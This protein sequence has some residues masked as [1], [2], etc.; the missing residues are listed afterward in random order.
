LAAGRSAGAPA[1]SDPTHAPIL[2]GTRQVFEVG[3]VEGQAAAERAA[4]INRRIESFVRQPAQIRPVEVQVRGSE[5][6]LVIGGRQILTVTDQ[7]AAD[8]LTT[9]PAL[10]ILWQGDL[11]N[12]LADVRAQHESF[13]TQISGAILQ[14]AEN[15]L[16][17]VA[18]LIPRLVSAL[19][20][21]FLTIFAARGS[22]SAPLR[23]L[24]GAVADANTRQIVQ[25]LTYYTVWLLGW[26]VAFGTLGIDPATLVAGLGITTIAL[27]FALKDLLSNFVSGFLILTTRPFR[28]GDEIAV[29]EFEGTVDRIDLRATHLRTYYNRLVL[30][31]NADLYTATIVNNTA[32]PHRR[33]EFVVGVAYDTDLAEARETAL[34]V[35]AETPGVLA[36]PPPDV[37]VDDL[38][39]DAIRLK[40]RFHSDPRRLQGVVVSSEVKRRL[41]QAFEAAGITI[42][43]ATPVVQIQY[44]PPPVTENGETRPGGGGKEEAVAPSRAA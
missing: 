11:E 35:A 2:V 19:L 1:R 44:P 41:L 40:L 26:V 7:D 32:T 36:Q 4:A 25:T 24:R 38:T 29:K 20:V 37:L 42:P 31:P 16:R 33:H 28:L 12:A 22:R 14:S 39:G 9:L 17:Q 13:W 18:A 34:Q 30:I 15:L 27:G 21:L 3:A 23:L 6:I 8:N 5:R 43:S 10:A